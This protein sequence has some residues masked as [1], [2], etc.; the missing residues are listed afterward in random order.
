[1]TAR[2]ISRLAAA[3]ALFGAATPALAAEVN[4]YTTREP[5]LIQ[6][7]LDAYTKATGTKVNAIFIKEGLAE[8]VAAEGAASPADILMV[9][10]YG[11]LI[12][13]VDKGLAQP[14]KSAALDAAIPPAFRDPEGR[15]FAT[16]M[17]ARVVYASKDRLPDLKALTYE[18][19]ADPKWKGKVCIR[20]GQHPYNTSLIAAVID[21]DGKDGAKAWLT[22]LKANLARKPS[23]GDREGAKDILAGTCDL[24]IGNSY[25]V[26]LMRSGKGGADQKTWADSINVILPTFAKSGGTHANV[27]GAVV[28]KNAPNRDEAVKLLEFLVTDQGQKLFAETNYEY[29]VKAGAKTDPIVEAFG[30]F[31]PDD[32]PLVEIAKNRKAAA[33][34]V[35]EV[36]FND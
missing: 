33:A 14:I 8:R 20:S 2:L 18:E 4:I 21:K 23:G 1:M 25:Y 28:A 35:D 12:D 9:V 7:M 3:C 15:W 30:T 31:E 36:G 17:R 16:S 11:N 5:G 10:D 6:P 13:L 26:G 22:G 34:L 19:L 24:A 27:S 32:H 29:P